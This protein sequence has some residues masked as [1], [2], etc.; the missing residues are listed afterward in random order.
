M[1][2]NHAD[3]KIWWKLKRLIAQVDY[4]TSRVAAIDQ[5]IAGNVDQQL[6]DGTADPNTA[7]LLPNNPAVPAMYNQIINGIPVHQWWWNTA[8]QSWF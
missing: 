2:F 5:H 8:E 6:Y 1:S 4:L 3:Y 7:G